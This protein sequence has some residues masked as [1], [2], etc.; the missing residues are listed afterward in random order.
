M[1]YSDY[2]DEPAAPA[3]LDKLRELAEAQAEQEQ[4]VKRL[5]AELKDAKHSLQDIAERQIPEA[6]DSVGVEK[7]ETADGLKIEL[8]DK[9]RASIPNANKAAA[10]QWLDD[11]GHGNLIK[12][13]LVVE[14]GRRDPEGAQALLE[15]LKQRDLDG[16]VGAKN[17]VHPQ[18]LAAFLRQALEQG[19]DVPLEL[20]G[21]YHQ[22]SAKV[23]TG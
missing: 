8:Q 5:E 10:Y 12:R 2:T 11:H 6:M 19:E 17:E 3:S 16:E 14:F 21:A 7:F 20:F 4:E 13:Q 18:T 23:K 9:L 15:E 1:D 22:R